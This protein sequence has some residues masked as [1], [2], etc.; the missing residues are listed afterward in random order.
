MDG[1]L[2]VGE[3]S[4]RLAEA[5]VKESL[6]RIRGMPSRPRMSLRKDHKL[7]VR[8]NEATIS[9]F[10]VSPRLP[11][12]FIR[13]RLYWVASFYVIIFWSASSAI[14]KSNYANGSDKAL[15]FWNHASSVK[16]SIFSMF[17][18]LGDTLLLVNTFPLYI[19]S[20]KIISDD[21]YF[22]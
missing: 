8:K 4:P 11:G 21:L 19:L 13:N 5:E 9:R 20:I 1:V 16:V 10:L 15:K 12:L 17:G 3:N 2:E 22:S 7:P 18:F 14:S 6:H